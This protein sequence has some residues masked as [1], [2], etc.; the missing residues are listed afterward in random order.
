MGCNNKLALLK[1]NGKS[2][3]QWLVQSGGALT[4]K[5]LEKDFK[6]S[7]AGCACKGPPKCDAKTRKYCTDAYK[8]PCALGSKKAVCGPCIKGYKSDGKH[9]CVK[10]TPPANKAAQPNARFHSTSAMATAT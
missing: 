1:C 3:D 8:T 9:G 4:C 5:T 10:Y 7:C 2:C 6:C